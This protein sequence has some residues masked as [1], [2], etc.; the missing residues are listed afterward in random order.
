ML[1]EATIEGGP[2]NVFIGELNFFLVKVFFMACIPYKLSNLLNNIVFTLFYHFSN[3][4]NTFD[5]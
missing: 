3:F 2:K 5:L 4:C 1:L